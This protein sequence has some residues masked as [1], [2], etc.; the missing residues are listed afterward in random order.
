M[1]YRAD[2]EPIREHAGDQL[3]LSASPRWGAATFRDWKR[4]LPAETN[5]CPIQLPGGQA[6]LAMLSSASRAVGAERRRGRICFQQFFSQ[7]LSE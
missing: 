5:V 3:R 6:M 1:V 2:S 4:F 7:Q